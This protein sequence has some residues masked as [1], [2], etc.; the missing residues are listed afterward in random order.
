MIQSTIAL[1]GDVIM[2]FFTVAIIY[3]VVR[4]PAIGEWEAA[5]YA[6]AVGCFAYSNVKGKK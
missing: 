3:R 2:M 1:N 4:G 6:T 5:V